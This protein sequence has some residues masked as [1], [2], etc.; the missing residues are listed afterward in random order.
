MDKNTLS[1]SEFDERIATDVS[2]SE[3]IDI[4]KRQYLLPGEYVVSVDPGD[5]FHYIISLDRTLGR[6]NVA[7]GYDYFLRKGEI[8]EW[9]HNKGV[10]V[11]SLRLEDAVARKFFQHKLLGETTYRVMERGLCIDVSVGGDYSVASNGTG[12]D[13]TGYARLGFLF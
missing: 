9:V 11:S 3:V 10:D 5:I 2:A 13:W 1:K 12:K 7:F 4:F 8:I 6:W